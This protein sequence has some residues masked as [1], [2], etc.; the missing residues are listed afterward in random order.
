[1]L[2]MCKR[3]EKVEV[4]VEKQLS[5]ADI[6]AKMELKEERKAEV[7][8]KILEARAEEVKTD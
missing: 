1:M 4:A 7:K 8:P 3:E 5:E 6:M 2:V